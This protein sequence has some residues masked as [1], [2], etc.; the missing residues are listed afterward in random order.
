M[1]AKAPA[2]LTRS[3][4]PEQARG[5][6]RW[7]EELEPSE[8]RALRPNAGRAPARVVVRHV[9]GAELDEGDAD[10]GD[11]YEYLVN[12]E[13]ILDGERTYRICS[14]H[15]EA[16]AAIAAGRIPA[17]FRCPLARAACPMRS[18]LDEAPGCDVRFSIALEGDSPAELGPG[19]HT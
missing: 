2:L 9:A 16:R 6:D 13:I 8:R 4:S 18:L 7:W 19:R 10:A 5:V 1:G 15:P 3:L 14:A 12:H 17:E 11:F